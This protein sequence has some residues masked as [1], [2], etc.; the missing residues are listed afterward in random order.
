MTQLQHIRIRRAQAADYQR[1]C[2]L[3]GAL[4]TYHERL[5]P[6]Q[7]QSFD[8]PPRSR[9]HYTHLITNPDGYFFG[10]EIDEELVGFINGA[11]GETPPYPMFK[12]KRF[13]GVTNLF[14]HTEQ[15]GAGIGLAL[16]KEAR[17]WGVEKGVTAM[18][19]DVIADNAIALGFYEHLGF[20]QIRSTL[21][22]DG[23][24]EAE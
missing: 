5:A 15:R 12:P 21:E 17:A 10:A 3:F 18:R 24:F 16:L 14:V 13:V 23:R 4:D 19:L 9:S 11:L 6:N 20:S 22:I 1:V 8:E 7:Y 2:A